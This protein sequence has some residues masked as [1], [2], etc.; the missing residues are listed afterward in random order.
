M[1]NYYKNKYLKYKEKYLKLRNIKGGGNQEIEVTLINM[2]GNKTLI[3]FSITKPIGDLKELLLSKLNLY[4]LN[5]IYKG[6]K[7][8]IEKS[9]YDE[10]DKDMICKNIENKK[11]IIQIHY[12]IKSKKISDNPLIVEIT[13]KL[14]ELNDI[15]RYGNITESI[16]FISDL[17][18]WI[19]KDDNIN[20]TLR[21]LIKSYNC[22]ENP[23]ISNGK[24]DNQIEFKRV[25]FNNILK[26]LDS[27]TDNDILMSICLGLWITNKIN[28]HYLENNDFVTVFSK[29]LEELWF[30]LT[31]SFNNIIQNIREFCDNINNV[32]RQFYFMELIYDDDIFMPPVEINKLEYNRGRGGINIIEIYDDKTNKNHT[33]MLLVR[34][35]A[36]EYQQGSTTTDLEYFDRAISNVY[37]YTNK[38]LYSITETDELDDI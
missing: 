7:L 17:T 29:L 22:H 32:T 1:N 9:L 35:Y 24:C 23:N 36:P 28:N 2:T 19:I 37:K 11:N 13:N 20:S 5:L 14:I 31:T 26:N 3:Q 30:I 18:T 4:D 16:S 27:Y 38:K 8:D 10:I 33:K 15:L 6:K 12:I 34:G 25:K 21:N